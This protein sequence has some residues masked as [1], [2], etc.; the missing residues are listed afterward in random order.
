M[1]RTIERYFI[2]ALLGFAPVLTMLA[3][4]APDG[5]LA[6]PM[7]TIRSQQLLILGAELFV[8]IVALRDGLLSTLR[9]IRMPVVALAAVLVLL[10]IALVTAWLAPNP[11]QA[12]LRTAYWVIHILFGL[13]IMHLS[14]RQLDPVDLYRGY[15]AGFV[16]FVLLFLL[17]AAQ[18]DDPA[19]FDWTRGLPASGHI[20]HYGYHAA[21]V[22]AFGAGLMALA[23][24]RQAWAAAFVVMS[25]ALGFAL[26]TGSRGAILAFVAAVAASLVLLPAVRAAKAWGAAAASLLLSL[27]VTFW[28]PAPASN[29]GAA[30]A[31]AAS[32]GAQAE[33]GITTGRTELWRLVLDAIV[34]RPWFGH[35]EAQM[36]TV[37]TYS[38]MVHP[39]N[40]LLQALLAWGIVGTLCILLLMAFLARRALRQVRAAPGDRVPAF[41]AMTALGTYALYD[42]TLYHVLP[43]SIFAACAGIIARDLTEPDDDRLRRLSEGAT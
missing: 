14:A 27:V 9:D 19:A 22:A 24:T 16:S 12:Q 4:W 21:A 28:L 23:R 35:G 38:T 37:A 33:G 43:V 18:V 17:F 5:S 13:S 42:G 41:M 20:R 3:T 1:G 40:I 30:R 36:S 31:V 2:P 39:H 6:G 32:A 10:A 7:L 34:D 15:A 11:A 25:V 29:M 26:W 8:I